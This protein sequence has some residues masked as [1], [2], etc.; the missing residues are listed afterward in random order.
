MVLESLELA[1]LPS[2]SLTESIDCSPN[3]DDSKPIP[4]VGIDSRCTPSILWHAD[5]RFFEIVL[6]VRK[7]LQL[8]EL[9]DRVGVITAS[10]SV[11][12]QNLILT[13]FDHQRCAWRILNQ[14]R[15]RHLFRL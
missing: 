10:H 5:W 2:F 1:W 13:T 8:C 15:I 9:V 11:L 3:P 4:K 14:A 12:F 6:D 7:R